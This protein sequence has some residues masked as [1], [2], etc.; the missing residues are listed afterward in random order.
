MANANEKQYGG[1]HYKKQAIQ[2]WD[3]ITQNKLGYLEGTAIKYISRWR[4]KGGVEDI[5][6]AIHFL[7]KLLE[8]E[9]SNE[10]ISTPYISNSERSSHLGTGVSDVRFVPTAR[11]NSEYASM[12]LS[13]SDQAWYAN[14]NALEEFANSVE[15]GSF[16]NRLFPTCTTA[17]SMGGFRNVRDVDGQAG[18]SIPI[19]PGELND[20]AILRTDSVQP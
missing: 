7:E 9:T 19:H 18:N 13:A 3:F 12:A 4:D 8:T 14:V 6:K 1:T 10:K 16:S 20:V 11:S 17:N 5:K 15:C 2:A